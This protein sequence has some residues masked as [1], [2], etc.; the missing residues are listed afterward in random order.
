MYAI[1]LLKHICM[2]HCLFLPTLVIN[3][4]KNESKN[5]ITQITRPAAEIPFV[6]FPEYVFCIEWCQ[7]VAQIHSEMTYIT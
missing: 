4:S 1:I 5:R 3:E 2:S 7:S 6:T